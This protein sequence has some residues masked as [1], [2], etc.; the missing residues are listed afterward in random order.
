MESLAAPSA[1]SEGGTPVFV[2]HAARAAG[3]LPCGGAAATE[4]EP[5]VG[6]GGTVHLVVDVSGYFD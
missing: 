3:R 4:A 1:Y 6:G 5:A 2:P